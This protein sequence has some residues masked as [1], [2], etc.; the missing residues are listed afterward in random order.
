MLN[1][2]PYGF[3]Y[4]FILDAVV[5]ITIDVFFL[6]MSNAPTSTFIRDIFIILV[7]SFA[8]AWFRFR[9]F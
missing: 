8:D 6:Q 9:S 7:I 2:S 5:L 4:R 1:K 3:L